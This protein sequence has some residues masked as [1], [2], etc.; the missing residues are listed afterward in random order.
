M[1]P[2]DILAGPTRT[3]EK[4]S[5]AVSS[6]TTETQPRETGAPS[7]ETGNSGEEFNTF[8]RLLTA[9]IQNQDPLAPLDSTQ[10]VE[11]LATF[12]N[13]ELQATSNQTLEEIAF[14]LSSQIN[15][16]NPPTTEP[17]PAEP[18]TDT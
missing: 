12:T 6:N 9:Q 15:P 1:T 5:Q 10:F 7:I 4:L 2:T 11:Q 17:A 13:L 3:L 8:L 18:T 16:F 14:L